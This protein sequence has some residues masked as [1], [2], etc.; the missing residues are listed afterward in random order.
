MADLEN[1]PDATEST[2]VTLPTSEASSINSKKKRKKRTPK[3]HI[4]SQFT[5][6]NPPWAYIHLEH[7]SSSENKNLLDEVTAQLHLT[8]ALSQF[9]GL[10][11]AAIPFD[12]LKVE[13]QDVWI[14]LQTE[15]R[16]A[17]V[18][19]VGGWV[20]ANGEGWRVKGWSSWDCN[21]MGRESGQDLFTD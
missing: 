18:A 8:A 13:G 16:Q 3:K 2:A 20:N 21:A 10:H 11:G 1:L 12:I 7:L 9:L 6:R 17:L 15:D 14:R 19:A 4:L 5:I